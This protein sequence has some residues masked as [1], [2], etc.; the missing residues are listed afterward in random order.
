MVE[1]GLVAVI[2]A[3]LHGI[4]AW[5]DSH[6][7]FNPRLFLKTLITAV[8]AGALFTSGYSLICDTPET[9]DFIIA[10]LAGAMGN[11]TR[12]YLRGAVSG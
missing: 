9:K 8:V 2:G 3:V 12:D 7:P 5:L 6:E 11:A 4:G 1:I 10:F